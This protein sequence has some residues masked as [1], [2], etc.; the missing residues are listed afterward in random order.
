MLLLP[1]IF[2]G[3]LGMAIIAAIA[4]SLF[5]IPVAFAEESTW[6]IRILEG[7]S[8]DGSSKMFFPAELPVSFGDTIEWVNEDTVTHSITSGLPEH[9]DYHGHFFYP[10]SVEPNESITLTL[11]NAGH[12][13]YYYLCEIHP[14]MEGK[15]FVAESIMA[16]PETKVPIAVN[17]G[18]L[19]QGK[20][21]IVSG[22]VHQDFWGTEYEILVYDTR[23]ELVDVK[24]GNF[25]K[26]SEYSQKIETSSEE[27][28]DN[29]YKVKLVY[30]LPSKVAQ[31]SFEFSNNMNLEKQ[32]PEWIKDVGSYWC[33]D[34]IEDSEF[35]NAIQFL[36][37]KDV[38]S[39]NDSNKISSQSQEI[40]NWIKSNTCWWSENQISDIDFLS[41][42]EF[43]VNKGTIR[44]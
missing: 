30:A 11:I 28:T 16:Q 4:I 1:A 18:V 22:K 33:N 12:D 26:N 41:G 29:L 40:P 37:E 13:A 24:Y 10:G 42:I 15:I 44:L 43:L 25:D 5:A 6:K 14:W 8:E 39:I 32:V 36:I 19:Q 23:N 27:W 3:F 31:T 17:G 9:P 7:S 20:P 38:I 21:L 34:E 2:H 35:V